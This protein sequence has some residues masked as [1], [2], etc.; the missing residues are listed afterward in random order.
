MEGEKNLKGPVQH[1]DAIGLS[2]QWHYPF[3]LVS[4]MRSFWNIIGLMGQLGLGLQLLT[5]D[6]E[7]LQIKLSLYI[8]LLNR[9]SY[10]RDSHTTSEV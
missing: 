2:P 5:R 9:V 3:T 6:L 1:Q 10:H 7:K 4:A 8:V